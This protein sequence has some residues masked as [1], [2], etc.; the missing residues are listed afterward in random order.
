MAWGQ[1][2]VCLSLARGNYLGG[3]RVSSMNY[4]SSMYSAYLP[5][6]FREQRSTP[7]L[8]KKS[9][10]NAKGNARQRCVCEG[11]V[12]TKSKLTTMFHLDST[13]DDAGGHIQCMDFSIARHVQCMNSTIGWKS[14]FFSA[15]LI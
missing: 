4:R 10:A 8:N 15:P 5:T 2:R 12:R 9:P 3:P 14:Q 1:C 11:P 7:W 13:A 6:C